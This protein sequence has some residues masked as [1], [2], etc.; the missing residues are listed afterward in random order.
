[1]ET[2]Y[3]Y[4]DIVSLNEEELKY[5]L[6]MYGISIDISN[7]ISCVEGMKFIKNKFRIQKGIIVH[8]KDYSMY[9]GSQINAVDIESG[10][11]YGNLLATAKAE[12]GW[13][14]TREQVQKILDLP[15]SAKGMENLK[16]IA[17][18]KYADEAAL[19]PTKYIDKPKYTIG[20]GD[21]F[22]AGV[23]MCF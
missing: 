4:V 7:I 9:V 14:G 12:N 1:M 6:D 8:T 17:N 2:L 15:L 10:L 23:Q 13:Y 3:P 20:L 5:T 11:I 22:I 19:V 16:I 21:T 18:S